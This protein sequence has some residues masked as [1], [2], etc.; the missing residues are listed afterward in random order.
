MEE[1]LYK[2]L[3]AECWEEKRFLYVK[4][5]KENKDDDKMDLDDELIVRAKQM[6]EKVIHKQQKIEEEERIL[7]KFKNKLDVEKNEEEKKR[8]R[9][10]SIEKKK[11]KKK[12]KK[13][14]VQQ[15]DKK[16]N[17]MRIRDIN[18]NIKIYFL[19][20]DCK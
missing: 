15:V 2:H 18:K 10:M 19:R 5:G 6:D 13:E 8:K 3:E 16:Q 4:D 12:T 9:Q 20:L 14:K 1:D 7:N 11:S 17:K